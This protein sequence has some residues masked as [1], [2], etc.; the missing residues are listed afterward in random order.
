MILV[1]DRSHTTLWHSILK[2]YHGNISFRLVKNDK[3]MYSHVVLRAY[4]IIITVWVPGRRV[5]RTK[6]RYSTKY[7]ALTGDLLA[8][9]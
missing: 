1:S 9:Y 8:Y 4:N 2:S 7:I 3:S 6:N 5:A